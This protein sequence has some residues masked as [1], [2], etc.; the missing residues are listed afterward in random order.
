MKRLIEIGK[1]EREKVNLDDERVR[2]GEENCGL[3]PDEDELGYPVE[4]EQD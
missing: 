1:Q 2:H 3:W 4:E